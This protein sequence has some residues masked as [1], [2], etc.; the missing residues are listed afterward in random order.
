MRSVVL[1]GLALLAFEPR[2]AADAR[3]QDAQPAPAP[4][5]AP[6]PAPSPAPGVVSPIER[7]RAVRAAFPAPSEKA[8]F[9]FEAE[10]LFSGTPLGT[11]T[12][13]AKPTGTGEGARWEVIETA[14][15]AASPPRNAQDHRTIAALRRDL[16][17]ISYY[18]TVKS[19]GVPDETTGV[20][21]GESGGFH[22]VRTG[23]TSL[24]R[25]LEA[26]S[27]LTATLAGLLVFLR[28]CPADAAT[29]EMPVFS[30][31]SSQAVTGRIEVKG[32]TPLK[33]DGSSI[34]AFFAI[35]SLGDRVFEIFLSAEDRKPLAVGQP[36]KGV[37]FLGKG[38][39][40]PPE[41][42]PID[43]T[44]PPATAKEAGER[45]ALG[46]L[47]GDWEIVKSSIDWPALLENSRK[48]DK[49]EGTEADLQAKILESLKPSFKAFDRQRAE[50]IIGR[51][52]SKATEVA[53]GD[54]VEVRFGPPMDAFGYRAKARDKSWAIVEMRAGR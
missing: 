18:R 32:A 42:H 25:P 16:G 43:T 51:A 6:A 14:S 30:S 29:Y 3:A 21:A 4:T 5:P 27:T 34:P 8:G 44:K 49:F 36:S 9:T 13:S 53:D 41:P 54:V 50:G 52:V 45:F 48:T 7:A 33:L 26:D 38:L 47:V 40:K 19:E 10:I 35:A 11:A 12:Y 23:A 1:L 39:R 20:T 31:D 28:Q 46:I 22:V 2:L 15:I 24:S 17:L 37:L